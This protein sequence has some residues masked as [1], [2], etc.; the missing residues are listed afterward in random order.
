[1]VGNKLWRTDPVDFARLDA[2]YGPFTIDAAA[3]DADTLV[4][5]RYCTELTDG[6]L[7]EHYRDGD[8]VF[9]NPPYVGLYKWLEVAAL[10]CAELV[11][12]SWLLVLP[13]STDAR[14]FHRFVWDEKRRRHR[15]A[16]DLRFPPG[17][18]HFIDPVGTGRDDPRAP[19][20]LVNFL[21]RELG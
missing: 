17:R 13:V 2:E 12:C 1:M 4:P 18:M 16:V 11:D 19:S 20:M 15:D 10:T 5:A 21:P 7:A 8:R 3:S 14:W 6:R 9:C